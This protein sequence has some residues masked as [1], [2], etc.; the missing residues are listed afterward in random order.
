[1]RM[2]L[3][4]TFPN[5]PFNTLVRRGETGK[6]M[7]KILGEL[8]PE[9]VYFTE[10]GGERTA[11][12]AIDLPTSSDIPK[13]AEPFFLNFNAKCRFR[14]VMSPDDLKRAGLEALGKKWG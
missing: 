9:A 5:E 1:M 3:Q 10:V 14:V 12:M 7:E 13:F 2:L 11:L 8:K 4:V 6:I